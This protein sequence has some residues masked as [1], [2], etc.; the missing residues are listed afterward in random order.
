MKP[1][2]KGTPEWSFNVT[3]VIGTVSMSSTGENQTPTEAAFR[4][5]G[6]HKKDGTY[7]FPNE[8]GEPC[9]ITVEGLDAPDHEAVPVS[10]M[11]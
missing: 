1:T 11:A 4:L 5:I 9:T 7:T 6:R 3:A 10:E 8:D 2:K